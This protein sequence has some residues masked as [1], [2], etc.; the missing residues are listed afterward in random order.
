MRRFSL[1]LLPIVLA[2]TFAFV[3]TWSVSATAWSAPFKVSNPAKHPAVA[4]DSDG[5]M[6]FVW[7]NPDKLILQYRHCAAAD[8]CDAVEKLPKLEGEASAPAIALN[9]LGQPTVVWSQEK[10]TGATLQLSVR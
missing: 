3:L 1:V 9:S 2:L 6:Y 10:G 7:V 8:T 4:I 5:E